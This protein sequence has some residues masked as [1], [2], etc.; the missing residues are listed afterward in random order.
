MAEKSILIR[1]SGPDHPGIT[2]ALM[3]LLSRFD[4]HI[5]DVEQI[6]IRGRLNLSLVVTLDL[7]RDARA[8]LLLFGYEQRVEIDF[9]EVSSQSSGQPPALV[10]T[11]LG[12]TVQPA[13]LGA[14]ASAVAKAGGNIDRIIRLAKYPVMAYE[15]TISGDDREGIRAGLLE[16]AHDLSCDIAV[17]RFGLSRRAKRLVVMDVD[18]TL[19]QDEAIELL[20]G[21]AGSLAEVA[22]LTE[23]AMAGEIDFAP[24]LERRVAT[25]A[26]LDAAVLDRVNERLRLSPGARTFIRTLRRLGFRTAIV[27]GG[28]TSVTDHLQTEL[29]ID[30]ALANTLEI[31]D[32]RLTGRTTGPVVDRAAKAA[33][34]ERIAAADAIPLDQVVAVGD[35]AND[36]DMLSTAGLGIAFNAKAVVR[37]AADTSVNVPYLDAV[38]FVLGMRRE[39]IEDADAMASPPLD[40]PC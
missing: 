38:L 29:G 26:G 13:E 30:H 24:S 16:R 1:I 17:H 11:L 40:Q 3:E 18:S 22:A 23:R 9:E 39:E 25:L 14:V 32:G 10:A 15:L 35:G 4:T 7:E 36:L 33:F 8:E 2:A 20:A 27:S 37:Q 19:I 34:V 21:E 28:F 12:V 31:V 5:E 6:V